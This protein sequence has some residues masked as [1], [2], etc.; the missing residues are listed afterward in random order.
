MNVKTHA[1]AAELFIADEDRTDW[2]NETL[3][4]VRQKRDKA[5]HGIPEWEHLREWASTIKNHTNC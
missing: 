2:H 5:A 1:D 4:F 3:W